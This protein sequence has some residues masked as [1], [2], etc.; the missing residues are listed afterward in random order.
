MADKLKSVQTYGR[1]KTATAVAHCKQGRGLLKVNGRPLEHMEPQILRLKLQEPI[2]VVG[3][4][5]FQDV[6]I[7][8]RVSGGGHV[9]QI[10]AI[11]QAIA[12]S[13]VA[14]YHKFVDEQSKRELKEQF[15]LY[16]KSLLVSDPRRRESKKF[17]GPGARARYQKSYR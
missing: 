9:A 12:R 7:R 17:G 2:L 8:V 4:D 16:D 14:Y 11:R 15:A 3:K 6:D 1:K 5:R 10:Y 13:L